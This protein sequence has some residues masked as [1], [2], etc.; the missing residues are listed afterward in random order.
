MNRITLT[1]AQRQ[2]L[3]KRYNRI[4]RIADA[5]DADS[6]IDLIDDNAA[7]EIIETGSTIID[8]GRK[9][10]EIL[11]THV[12]IK[13]DDAGVDHGSMAA[14]KDAR[15]KSDVGLQFTFKTDKARKKFVADWNKR[16]VRG[17]EIGTHNAD[18]LLQSLWV[19]KHCG[20]NRDKIRVIVSY[21]ASYA[22]ASSQIFV[23]ESDVHMPPA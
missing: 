22:G 2:K 20:K 21:A 19:E 4:V 13:S 16:C 15:A 14:D 9:S 23:K 1:E 8:V 17:Y 6:A 18:P 3:T 7:M 12:T 5:I 11:D 10:L